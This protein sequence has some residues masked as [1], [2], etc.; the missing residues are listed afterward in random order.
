M[1]ETPN[2]GLPLIVAQQAMKHVTHYES[3]I[4]LD[5]LVQLSVL[6]MS[7]TAPPV[8]LKAGDRYLIGTNPTD[9]FSGNAGSLAFFD[10]SSWRFSMPVTGWI[11]YNVGDGSFYFYDGTKWKMVFDTFTQAQNLTGLGIG[12][13]SDSI[14]RLSVKTNAALFSSLGSNEGGSGDLRFTLNRESSSKTASHLYQ[15]NWSGR[16]ETGLMG[17]D[18]W[19]LKLSANGNIWSD[20]LIGYSSTGAIRIDQ[21]LSGR[22]QPANGGR[23]EADFDGN[24]GSAAV[25]TDTTS[26]VSGLAVNFRKAGS[27]VGA[28][29]LSSSGTSYLTT[30][31]Y[32][33]KSNVT[34]IYDALARLKQLKP[35]RFSFIAEPNREIDGFIAHEVQDVVPEAVFGSKDA[36]DEQSN[37]I[38][39]TIDPSRLIPL[40]VASVL[41]LTARIETLEARVR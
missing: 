8:S 34:N 12:T 38:P 21:F 15:T 22:S 6:Q 27:T 30:S 16:A 37:I 10:G 18:N 19:R 3:L 32:R 35:R 23:I 40:L 28:I 24:T 9:I 20:A 11:V 36:V 17:D 31:D 14:N 39:Q 33:L 25:F 1:P 4:K 41:E 26:A 29:R 13:S 7:V 2:L 5:A